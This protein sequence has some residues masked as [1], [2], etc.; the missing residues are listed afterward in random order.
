MSEKA[1]EEWQLKRYIRTLAC[2]SSVITLDVTAPTSFVVIDHLRPKPPI[3]LDDIVVPVYPEVGDILNIRGDTDEIW[4]AHVLLEIEYSMTFLNTLAD[5]NT[6][7]VVAGIT[8]EH[9][10]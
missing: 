2:I 8:T 1:W 9:P 10:L 6:L 7:S 4:I 3:S 5:G